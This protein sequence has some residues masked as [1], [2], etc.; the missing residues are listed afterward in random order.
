MRRGGVFC[1]AHLRVLVMILKYIYIYMGEGGGCGIWT[2]RL[3]IM[4]DIATT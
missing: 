2:D 1:R 4:D 3:W